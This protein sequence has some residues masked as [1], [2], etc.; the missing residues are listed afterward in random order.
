M[1]DNPLEAKAEP[2]ISLVEAGTTI[3]C[4]DK[5]FEK[6]RDSIRWSFE[7]GSNI[8]EA[9]DL[10]ERKQSEQRTSTEFGITMDCNDEH[11]EK[12]RDSSR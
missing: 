1:L 11:N 9:S 4:N 3:D 2:Y 8:T 7:L 10:H 6:A 12:A 5:Q